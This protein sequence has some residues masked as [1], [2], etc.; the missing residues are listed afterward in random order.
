M[1]NCFTE[2]YRGC[3]DGW[4]SSAVQSDYSGCRR[5]F[6]LGRVVQ[7]CFCNKKLCNGYNK[8]L[9]FFC[10]YNFCGELNCLHR[11]DAY[12]YIY[13]YIQV[14]RYCCRV[15]VYEIGFLG[16]ALGGH[17]TP[18][19]HVTYGSNI[20]GEDSL[21]AAHHTR[22]QTER[23]Q[24]ALDTSLETGANSASRVFAGARKTS[25]FQACPTLQ[26]RGWMVHQ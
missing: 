15:S 19:Q 5:Q 9:F 26:E 4:T 11:K 25:T 17:S 12:I 1:S 16:A 23:T 7:W 10:V 3:F 22:H 2:I 20:D 6:Y 21:A 18:V 14:I 13:I 24:T 8:H